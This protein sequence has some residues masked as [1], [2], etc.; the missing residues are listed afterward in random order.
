MDI[1]HLLLLLLSCIIQVRGQ[2]TLTPETLTVLKGKEARFTCRP[3]LPEWT[4]MVWLMNG[5]SVLTISNKTGA[6]NTVHPNVTAEQ[7]GDGWVFV[8]NRTERHNEGSVVCDLQ[9]I[10]T[11]T[12]NLFV[13]ETGSVKVV[14]DNRLALKDSWVQFEC[15]TAGWYPAPTVQWQVK[16]KE[17]KETKHISSSETTKLNIMATKSSDVSC[18]ASVSALLTPLKSCARLTVVV[19]VGREKEEDVCSVVPLAIMSSLSALLLLLLLCIC[20]V[21]WLRRRRQ[22]RAGTQEVVRSD[23]SVSGRSSVAEATA[24]KVNLGYSSDG[25]TDAVHNELIMETFRQEDFVSFHKVPDVI[26]PSNL[27]PHGDGPA[28]VCLKEQNSTNTRRMTTV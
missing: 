9:G 3:S 6:L 25:P 4:V 14:L 17:G 7:S 11:K 15:L 16:E 21:L 20:T 28:Q 18:L 1:I 22:A 5:K 26:S 27:S 13:Q 8:I 2:V 10:T 23:Q 19:E 24:G 12:A